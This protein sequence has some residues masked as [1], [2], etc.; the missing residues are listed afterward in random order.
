MTQSLLLC[1]FVFI[2]RNNCSPGS[3]YG[4]IEAATDAVL[5]AACCRVRAFQL[6]AMPSVCAERPL[7]KKEDVD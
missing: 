4:A 3:G 5:V 1:P 6:S 7:T 2:N